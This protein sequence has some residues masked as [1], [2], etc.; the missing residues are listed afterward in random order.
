MSRT[1]LLRTFAAAAALA[2]ALP[3]AHAQSSC[4]SDG[5]PRPTALLERFI[6]ADC[7][8]CWSERQTPAAAR[9]DLAIDWIVP[10]SRGDE[11][12]LAAAATRDALDRLQALAAPVPAAARG[13]RQRAVAPR[14]GLRVAHG[15]P[16]NGYIGASIDFKAAGPGP[17]TGWLALVE[18]LPAGTEGTPVQRL[19]VRNLLQVPWPGRQ[20]GP[21]APAGRLFESRP[22]NIPSGARPERLSVVGWIEDS[23]GHIRA[24]A[25]SGCGADARGG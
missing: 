4:S 15:L 16:F 12:P 20:P 9:G 11:A 22:M 17:W 3:W 6:N 23:R 1:T 25:Q 14:P 19:L 7:E 21:G 13:A 18:K 8:A 5:Q 24:I 10:G 2:L